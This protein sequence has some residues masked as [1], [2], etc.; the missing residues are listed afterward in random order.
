MVSSGMWACAI[1]MISARPADK[2][3]G[4]DRAPPAG[5]AADGSGPESSS[6]AAD[7]RGGRVGRRAVRLAAAVETG[8]GADE[9]NRGCS[10]KQEPDRASKCLRIHSFIEHG[11]RQ[12]VPLH[13]IHDALVPAVFIH[14]PARDDRMHCPVL[15]IPNL[16]SY[17]LNR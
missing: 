6:R 9:K 7:G 17:I 8:K 16:Q 12:T 13:I 15:S 3:A 1:L 14:P 5:T 4:S 11:C 10:K 2:S